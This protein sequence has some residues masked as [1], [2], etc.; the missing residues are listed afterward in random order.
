MT[1]L[2]GRSLRK[3]TQPALSRAFMVGATDARTPTAMSPGGRDA[4]RRSGRSAGGGPGS[5]ARP[6][7]TAHTKGMRIRIFGAWLPAVANAGGC[8]LKESRDAFPFWMDS[9]AASERRSLTRRSRKRLSERRPLTRRS[10][11]GGQNGRDQV[12]RGGAAAGQGPP[13]VDGS[14]EEALHAGKDACL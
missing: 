8:N 5:G 14:A 10:G 11:K 3:S 9:Q 2:C 1:F 12:Y 4:L 6:A 7:G 13:Q